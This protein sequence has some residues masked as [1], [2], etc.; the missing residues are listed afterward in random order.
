MKINVFLENGKTYTFEKIEKISISESHDFIT[1]Y[2]DYGLCGVVRK[3]DLQVLMVENEK[4][5]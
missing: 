2:S 4:D 5:V 1:M 3:N